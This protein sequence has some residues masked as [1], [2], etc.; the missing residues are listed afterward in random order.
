MSTFSSRMISVITQACVSVVV[1]G[2][3]VDLDP[4]FGDSGVLVFNYDYWHDERSNAISV[5]DDGKILVAGQ[6]FD[7]IAWHGSLF[8]FRCLADGTPDPGFGANSNGYVRIDLAGLGAQDGSFYA[9]DIDELGRPILAGFVHAEDDRKL[10]LVRL[11]DNG[12]LD[13]SFAEDGVLWLDT[14]VDSISSFRIASA[15]RAMPDGGIIVAGYGWDEL[16]VAHIDP[17]GHP[18]QTF[19]PDGILELFIPGLV[20]NEA[21]ITIQPDGAVIAA[22]QWGAVVKLLPDGTLDPAFGDGGISYELMG[23]GVYPKAITVRPAGG[24]ITLACWEAGISPGTG[25]VLAAQLNPSG[26]L[27]T[28]FGV[29]GFTLP[30]SCDAVW[31]N[32]IVLTPEGSTVIGLQGQYAASESWNFLLV[33]FDQLGQVETQFGDDG[34][35]ETDVDETQNPPYGSNDAL[36]GL[37][38]QPDGRIVGTGP[39]GNTAGWED[40]AIVRYVPVTMMGSPRIAPTGPIKVYPDPV[41]DRMDLSLEGLGFLPER[42]VLID[43]T[44]RCIGGSLSIKPCG[45]RKHGSIRVALPPEVAPGNYVLM[46]TREG[47]AV[48]VPVIVAGP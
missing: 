2:Q 32:D 34:V 23:S 31:V 45:S 39:T 22:E 10:T 37:A 46:L 40:V 24:E 38:I 25:A 14:D 47:N 36:W 43:L 42:A 1:N 16:L 12:M 7:G 26:H 35:L 20:F 28:N 18:D 13:S 3:H 4:S 29:G 11:A 33:G 19:A 21:A 6:D 41:V 8:A 48:S 5:Q 44:G 17:N 27:D 30:A 15:V 9:A